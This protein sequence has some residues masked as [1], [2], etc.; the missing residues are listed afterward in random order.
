MTVTTQQP[1]L[2][3][4]L[5]EP[6]RERRVA[7]VLMMLGSGLSTQVGASVAALAF[8]V[9]GPVGVVAVRQWVAGWCWSLSGGRGCGP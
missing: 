2:S 5:L 8:P 6:A 9:I 7:G 4:Q 1:D 3:A